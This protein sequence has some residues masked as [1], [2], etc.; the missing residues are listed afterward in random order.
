VAGVLSLGSADLFRQSDKKARI[1]LTRLS[2]KDDSPQNTLAFQYWPET[3]SDTKATNWANKPVPGGNLPLY[4]WIN[5]GERIISFQAVFTTDVDVTKWP[6]DVNAS[7]VDDDFVGEL[8]A[9]GLDT[10][11]IDIRGALLWLRSFLMPRYSTDGTYQPPA[12]CLLQIPGSRIGLYAG[13]PNHSDDAIVAIMTQC[14]FDYRAFFP[15]G[16]PRVVGVSLAFAQLAQYRGIVEF[17][18]FSQEI[19]EGINSGAGQI[20]QYKIGKT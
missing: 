6:A 16:V 19:R 3:I 9:K 4:S 17:P 15:N 13:G 8:K 10:R 12:K 7:L 18:G 2:P 20:G 5:G 14:D 1:K 11:N